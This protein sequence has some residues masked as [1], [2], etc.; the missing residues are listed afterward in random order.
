MLFKTVTKHPAMKILIKIPSSQSYQTINI[1]A[2]NTVKQLKAHIEHSQHIEAGDQFLTFGCKL[3]SDTV[4]LDSYGIQEWST[5]QLNMRLRGGSDSQIHPKEANLDHTDRF[6][7]QHNQSI[8]SEGT[9]QDACQTPGI[10]I[11]GSESIEELKR[12]FL[13]GSKERV[14][15]TNAQ[16]E[17]IG[18]H[19]SE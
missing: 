4:L 5:I 11:K 15:R 10:S 13:E 17:R 6:H 1:S 3:L 16:F 7:L 9:N 14:K 2:Q 18:E 19:E 8:S 12:I